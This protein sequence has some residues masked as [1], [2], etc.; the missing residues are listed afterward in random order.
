MAGA[1]V[2][3]T[4]ARSAAFVLSKERRMRGQDVLAP[5]V[6]CPAGTSSSGIILHLPFP[7]T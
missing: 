1:G 5:S 4:L 3:A 2:P 6:C 7:L